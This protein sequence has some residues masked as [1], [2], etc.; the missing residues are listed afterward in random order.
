MD[1]RD[2]QI[3]EIAGIIFDTVECTNATLYDG[4]G[5]PICPLFKT[6]SPS[7]QVQAFE[8]LKSRIN[9]EGLQQYIQRKQLIWGKAATDRVLE[10]LK[11]RSLIE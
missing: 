10:N 6:L 2:E 3:R 7:Q 8:G 4:R 9:T 11:S 1:Y 5:S